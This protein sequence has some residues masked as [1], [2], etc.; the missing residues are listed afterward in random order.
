M[1]AIEEEDIETEKLLNQGVDINAV[2]TED[3]DG[4]RAL[5]FVVSGTWDYLIR[6][7]GVIE[8]VRRRI[9][10]VQRLVEAGADV[11][12]RDWHAWTPLHAAAWNW[13]AWIASFL[14]IDANVNASDDVRDTPLCMTIIMR[15]PSVVSVL[16]Q[17]R[18][19]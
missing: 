7:S 18:Q 3:D 19:S 11:N 12:K 6:N 1:C 16:L 14:L 13:N 17:C 2:N 4:L 9:V 8:L 5:H 10:L 15:R